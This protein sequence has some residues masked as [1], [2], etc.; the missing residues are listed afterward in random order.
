MAAHHEHRSIVSPWVDS[1]SGTRFIRGACIAESGGAYCAPEPEKY[2][3]GHGDSLSL[4]R[5]AKEGLIE[6]G[7]SL[8]QGHKFWRSPSIQN[9]MY[10]MPTPS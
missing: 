6:M 7:K 3:E 5:T 4:A 10:A 8:K 9:N 1:D 2:T